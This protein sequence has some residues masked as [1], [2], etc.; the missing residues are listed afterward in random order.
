[1]I[2]LPM[3]GPKKVLTIDE[4]MREN[5]SSLRMNYENQELTLTVS[6]GIASLSA[7]DGISKKEFLR[8]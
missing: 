1:M 5:L 7:K 8:R 4:R 6:S 2:I 3:T